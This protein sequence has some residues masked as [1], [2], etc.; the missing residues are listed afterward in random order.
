MHGHSGARGP[1][2]ASAGEL[3][4]ICAAVAERAAP[5][6]RVLGTPEQ[7]AW[8]EAS[9]D[10][11]WAAAAGEPVADG[12]AEALDELGH[13][14]DEDEEDDPGSA[15]FL[16]DRSL[17]LVG[18]ALAGAL[19]RSPSNA[20]LALNT[21]RTVA[22][23]LDVEV[24]GRRPVVVRYGEPPPPPGPLAEKELGA[25][26]EVTALLAARGEGVVPPVVVARARAA[27]REHA[28]AFT[29]VVERLAVLND[30]GFDDRGGAP[31][32]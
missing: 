14:L 12:C 9:L 13:D 17:D 19:R 10:L 28:A 24:M 32:R 5:L 18:I 15:E 3:L 29:P 1:A 20:V 7:V 27:A 25:Q 21:L 2:D 30:W 22:G 4:V 8:V 26:R 31:R 23:L 6:C 16:V 11:A